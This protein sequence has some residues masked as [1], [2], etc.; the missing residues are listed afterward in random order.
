M[1]VHSLFNSLEHQPIRAEG[2]Y[3]D[4]PGRCDFLSLHPPHSGDLPLSPPPLG[5]AGYY[6]NSD[7]EVAWTAI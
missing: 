1:H 4:P 7:R 6:A 3:Y 5:P 2:N